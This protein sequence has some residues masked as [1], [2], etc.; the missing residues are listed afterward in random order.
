MSLLALA[1]EVQ[2]EPRAFPKQFADLLSVL[3]VEQANKMQSAANEYCA[4][5]D[6][7]VVAELYATE[8]DCTL[9][10]ASAIAVA[11]TTLSTFDDEI[12]PALR[13]KMVRNCWGIYRALGAKD[14]ENL[15]N[16]FNAIEG[17]ELLLRNI[18][19]A[20]A[21]AETTSPTGSGYCEK[22][23][24][25]VGGSYAALEACERQEAEAKRR[26]RR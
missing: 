23:A 12:V 6:Y 1:S 14:A 3:T 2:A 21:R 4:S 19:R 22:F 15:A 24:Q 8:S 9:A 18:A 16:C 25:T 11:D 5:L 7:K 20:D 17:Y 10:Q 26:V 13:P